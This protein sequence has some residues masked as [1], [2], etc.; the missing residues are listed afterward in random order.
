MEDENKRLGFISQD[1]KAYSPDKV[2]NIIGS[3]VITEEQGESSR[4]IITMGCS[5]KVCVLWE[6]VQNQ[7]E[8]INALGPK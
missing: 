2:D 6:I 8:R 3:S 5:R 4:E 1:V 7:N